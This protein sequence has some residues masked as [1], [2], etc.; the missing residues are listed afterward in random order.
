METRPHSMR[1]C[2]LYSPR[3]LYLKYVNSELRYRAD[4]RELREQLGVRQSNSPVKEELDPETKDV[5]HRDLS[6]LIGI[7]I[8]CP[9]FKSPTLQTMTGQ[10]LR[11]HLKTLPRTRP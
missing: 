4:I 8:L 7:S 3:D 6:A 5:R 2:S 1:G 11:Y 9:E 10:E